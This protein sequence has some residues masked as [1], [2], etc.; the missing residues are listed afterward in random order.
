M[1]IIFPFIG[2]PHHIFHALPIAAEMAAMGA[3]VEVAVAGPDHLRILKQIDLV[4]PGFDPRITL[5]GQ[6]LGVHAGGLL[7]HAP[8]RVNRDDGGVLHAVLKA[9]GQE[10]VAGH[11]DLTVLECHALH[12][13]LSIGP[14]R[15]RG[16]DRMAG[17][18]HGGEC[19]Y[20]I[21]A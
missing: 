5:L 9:R 7:L 15:G 18:A 13:S 10:Q 21:G 2:E 3:D 19:R 17:S 11:G 14:L 20:S 6:T 1:R 4:Y 8:P 12:G 16:A